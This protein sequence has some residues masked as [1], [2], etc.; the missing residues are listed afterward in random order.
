[1]SVRPTRRREVRPVVPPVGGRKVVPDPRPRLARCSLV[2]DQDQCTATWR[3]DDRTPS[4]VELTLG[5]GP[6]QLQRLVRV[7]FP[8]LMP[9]DAD[10]V[11][12]GRL[13]LVDSGGRTLVRSSVLTGVLFDQ[14]WPYDLLITCGLPVSEQRFRSTR[15]LQAAHPGAA[16]LWPL[17]AGF[18]WFVLTV[19]LAL[20][21]LAGLAAGVVALTS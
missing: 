20:L 5:N 10:T 15:V 19:S 1:M 9:G 2:V 14:A 12:A 4:T 17:T 6:G 16:P 7:L 21:A 13:L 8:P 18:G 3:G 11:E